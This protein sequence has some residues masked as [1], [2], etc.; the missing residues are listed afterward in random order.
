MRRDSTYQKS[1]PR[2][3]THGH[4]HTVLQ[5]VPAAPRITITAHTTQTHPYRHITFRSGSLH[6]PGFELETDARAI[7]RESVTAGGVDAPGNPVN[8]QET[9]TRTVH[10]ADFGADMVGNNLFG[11]PA[12]A[13]V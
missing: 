4:T 5:R 9:N 1:T 10:R 13:N 6:R 3:V 12:N 8:H 2:H 7:E 11:G